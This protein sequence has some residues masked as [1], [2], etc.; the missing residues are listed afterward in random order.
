MTTIKLSPNSLGHYMVC[1]RFYWLYKIIGRRAVRTSV[2]LASGTAVHAAMAVFNNGGDAAAQDAAIDKVLAETPPLPEDYRSAG[3]IKDAVAAFRADLGSI[4]RTWTVEEVEQTGEVE[5]GQI[6]Y[7][8][9]S[10]EL[11]PARVIFEFRR[12]LVAV[13]PDGLRAVVDFKTA[14]RNEEAE[15]QASKN[16]GALMAYAATYEMQFPDRPVHCAYLV[17]IIMRKPSKTGISFEFPHDDVI[18]FPKDRLAEWRRQTLLTAREILERDP[19]N[20]DS[21]P[22]SSTT[23]GACR[24]QFGVC[25]YL[26]C[27]V[28]PVSDRM[29]KLQ[30][31]EFESSD[32]A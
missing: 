28:L 24:H 2:A 17:R 26:T 18:Y 5:L 32:H 1:R 31:D 14:S 10:G 25:D 16:S 23:L 11:A 19:Q 3:F 9:Q 21:W 12:D 6:E 27:C 8:T 22:L 13:L 15:L 20:P 7:R 4:M 29:L 30:T